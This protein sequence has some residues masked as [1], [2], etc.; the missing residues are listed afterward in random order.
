MNLNSSFI[1]MENRISVVCATDNNYV[2]YCGVML[3]SLLVHDALVDIYVLIDSGFTGYSKKSLERLERR[4]RGCS[5]KFL[6][7]DSAKLVDCRTDCNFDISVATYYRLFSSELLPDTVSKV[8]YLD[9]DMIIDRSL[10][11]L[12]NVDLCNKA[13]AGVQ[14]IYG[15]SEET[16]NRLGYSKTLGY[17][18]AGMLLINLDYWRK[19]Q[20]CERCLDYLSK[21]KDV[22]LWCD[23]DVLNAVLCEEKLLLPLKYNY[24]VPLLL[25]CHFK[26]Y[27][28]EF[29]SQ[30]LLEKKPA[31]IHY[32]SRTKP[33]NIE[34]YGLPYDKTWRQIK[35]MSL[36]RWFFPQNTSE[37]KI[38]T[39]VKRYILWPM[40]W[41]RSVLASYVDIRN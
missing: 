32:V 26:S 25:N 41:T 18:N 40:G 1:R 22:I 6:E 31:I 28:K 34:Y 13:I 5:I 8:I 20:V 17:V 33:W 37:N 38:K 10:Q 30:I 35:Q 36:W 16:F 27:S 11:D 15:E 3:S 7:V 29:Q 24:Q 9:C 14:D 39:V 12:W 21:N 23:Q 19:K 4:Y 2:P